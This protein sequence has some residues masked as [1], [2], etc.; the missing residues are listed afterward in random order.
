MI[1][2][3]SHYSSFTMGLMTMGST[4]IY[5]Y[6]NPKIPNLKFERIQGWLIRKEQILH[7]TTILHYNTSN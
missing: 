2:S 7:S 4:K 6:Y 1:I 3:L 5:Y